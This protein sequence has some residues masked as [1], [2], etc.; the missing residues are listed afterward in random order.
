MLTTG[1]AC[2]LFS[3]CDPYIKLFVNGTKEEETKIQDGINLFNANVIYLSKKIPK[4]TTI[5]I[6]VWDSD[7]FLYGGDDLI[8]ETEGTIDSFLQQPIRYGAQKDGEQNAIET[9][10][11]WQDERSIA[12]PP[13]IRS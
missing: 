1:S 12:A 2:D 11:F 7:S 5:K 10:V 3:A 13:L 6:Q 9:S 8:Q 4:T